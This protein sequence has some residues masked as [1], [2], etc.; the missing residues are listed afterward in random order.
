[1]VKEELA[2]VTKILLSGKDRENV[3]KNLIKKGGKVIKKE[4][5]IKQISS[6]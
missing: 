3:N 4:L 5:Q 6:K 1:M 2:K